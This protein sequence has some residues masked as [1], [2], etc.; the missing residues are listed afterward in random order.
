MKKIYTSIKN[1]VSSLLQQVVSS[2]F[3]NREQNAEMIRILRLMDDRLENLE[4]C[5]RNDNHR[6]RKSICTSHW[7]D[8]SY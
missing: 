6:N 2:V 8:S 1:R 4:E 3:R 5:I 7:N